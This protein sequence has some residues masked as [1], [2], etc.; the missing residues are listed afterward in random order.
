MIDALE[1][2]EKDLRDRAF[3]PC[4][5]RTIAGYLAA[6]SSKVETCTNALFGT[7]EVIR[8]TLDALPLRRH[9]EVLQSVVTG[10]LPAMARKATSQARAFVRAQEDQDRLRAWVIRAGELTGRA[11]HAFFVTLVVLWSWV[12]GV[13]SAIAKPK[14]TAP[15]RP[16]AGQVFPV[17]AGHADDDCDAGAPFVPHGLGKQD[18]GVVGKKP[19]KD[20]DA[21]VDADVGES[22]MSE[23]GDGGTLE[24]EAEHGTQGDVLPENQP[25]TGDAAAPDPLGCRAA[26]RSCCSSACGVCTKPLDACCSGCGCSSA[27]NDCCKTCSA[28]CDDLCKGCGKPFNDCCKGCSDPCK[29]CC[30]GCDDPCKSCCSGCNDP[31]KGCCNGCNCNGCCK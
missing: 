9:R 31:C 10:T 6:D 7:L 23:L 8:R 3:N 12:L 22:L 30:S 2:L 18:A 28:P 24:H 17:D 29:G 13:R 11:S 21:G 26:T 4:V 19:C 14:P 16:D 5:R 20:L 27:A 15:P 1:D 25:G